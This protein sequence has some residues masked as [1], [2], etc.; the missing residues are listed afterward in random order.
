MKAQYTPGPWYQRNQGSEIEIKAGIYTIGMVHNY[1][2]PH[3]A[4]EANAQ[5]IATAPEMLQALQR[6]SKAIFPN[7]SKEGEAL[8]K[9]YQD[10]ANDVIAKAT[11]KKEVR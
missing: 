7:L 8:L 1:N 9:I 10:L 11:E 4:N 6:F 5:L 3:E 2:E